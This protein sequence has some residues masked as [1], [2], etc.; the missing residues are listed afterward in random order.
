MGN[1][2]ITQGGDMKKID[3]YVDWKYFSTTQKFKTCSGAVSS[4]RGNVARMGGCFV[5][6]GGF[7]PVKDTAKIKAHI[8]KQWA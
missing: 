7:K 6:G 4:F 2:N 3:I 5:A 8:V 1:N